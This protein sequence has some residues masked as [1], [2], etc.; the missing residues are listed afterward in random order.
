MIETSTHNL[1]KYS[2][3]LNSEHSNSE[4]IWIVSFFLFGIQ[5]VANWM[6]PDHGKKFSNQMP[7]GYPTFYYFNSQLLIAIQD[8][9]WITN[10]LRNELFWTIWITN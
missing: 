8:I 4:L 6:V 3:D 9:A 2:G 5:M 10:H 7:F 1:S